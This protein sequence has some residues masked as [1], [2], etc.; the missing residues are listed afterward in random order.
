MNARQ[1]HHEPTPVENE[2]QLQE[3]KN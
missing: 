2:K 1:R 3:S